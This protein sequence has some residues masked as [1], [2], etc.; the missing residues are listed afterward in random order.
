M[1]AIKASAICELANRGFCIHQISVNTGIKLET[2]RGILRAANQNGQ[3]DQALHLSPTK[4]ELTQPQMHQLDFTSLEQRALD[5]MAQQEA[6]FREQRAKQKDL[7]FMYR[8]GGS[9][10]K[11]E[12]KAKP[13][14][15]RLSPMQYLE[16]SKEIAA[17]LAAKKAL[18][19]T[20]EKVDT[21]DPLTHVQ[22]LE[23]ANLMYLL[24]VGMNELQK[25]YYGKDQSAGE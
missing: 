15:S 24:Q 20:K 5:Y 17:V 21:I 22:H 8:Y 16:I 13:S 12:E 6:E 14:K 23:D 25:R 2:V 7:A 18:E 1:T 3:Y 19:K 11:E 9:P 4:R 10:G